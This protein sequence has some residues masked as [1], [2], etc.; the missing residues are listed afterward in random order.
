MKRVVVTCITN[1]YDTLKDPW[2]VTP[3][4]EYICFTD[5]PEKYASNAWE[6][7]PLP[8]QHP[9]IDRKI[10][11]LTHKYVDFDQCVWVDGVMHIIDDLRKFYD[12]LQVA[13]IAVKYHP[14]RNNY[15]DEIKRAIA[16]GRGDKKILT[17]QQKK[18]KSTKAKE[19]GLYEL[20]VFAKNNTPYTQ[21]FMEAWWEEFTE[22]PSRDQISFP[23]ILTMFSQRQLCGFDPEIMMN[24]F[25]NGF[26]KSGT[27]ETDVKSR[28]TRFWDICPWDS[29]KMVGERLNEF[30]SLMPDNDWILVRDG[31]TTHMSDS[32]GSRIE[33]AIE[34]NIQY[35]LLGSY[36]NR[37]GL[38]WQTPFLHQFNND[39]IPYHIQTAE[40]LWLEHEDIVMPWY[41]NIAGMFML[42]NN[43]IMKHVQFMPEIAGRE[44][45][46][47]YQFCQ[48]ILTRG[49]K[50]GILPGVY[51]LH[52]YRFLEGRNA[53][54]HSSHLYA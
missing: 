50:V 10:K 14:V 35:D 3:G 12:L 13:S 26:H 42:F 34:Q 20:G 39:N 25:C 24:F 19:K 47:D 6:I 48:D 8:E 41:G 31:D 15:A 28:T 32:Y 2:V 33:S 4:V 44:V 45:Y 43:Q 38:P 7:R 17:R 29:N 16:N 11:M 37:L 30:C 40:R 27:L 18:Y 49:G 5:H 54:K 46:L 21:A 1:D 22:F 52:L 53:A 36:T 23:Y 9:K 51:L